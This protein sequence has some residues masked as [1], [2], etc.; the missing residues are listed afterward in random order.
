MDELYPKA[1]FADCVAMIEKIGHSKWMQKMRREWI[2]ERSSRTS[3][4]A[5]TTIFID[6]AVDAAKT[7]ALQETSEIAHPMIMPP[8]PLVE[9]N[10]R[11]RSDN[12]AG[13]TK[14]FDNTNRSAESLFVSDSGVYEVDQEEPNLIATVPPSQGN[15]SLEREKTFDDELEAMAGI[16]YI[17]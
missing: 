7:S 11:R 10:A 16:D 9:R 5:G 15:S 4:R 6:L 14:D 3:V 1:K 12:L 17:V 13:G 2:Y 8:L